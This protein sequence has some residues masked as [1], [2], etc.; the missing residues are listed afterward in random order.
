MTIRVLLAADDDAGAEFT[1]STTVEVNTANP[2]WPAWL[3]DSI[4]FQAKEGARRLRD[5]LL[6][7]QAITGDGFV[8]L[9]AVVPAARAAR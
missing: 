6:A 8:P 7:Q 5:Q 9:A 1:V 3:V 4:T 2:R